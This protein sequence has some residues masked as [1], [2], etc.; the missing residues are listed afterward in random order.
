MTKKLTPEEAWEH[1]K[2]LW[3]D[4]DCISRRNETTYFDCAVYVGN[5]QLPL[6]FINID[7]PEGVTRWPPPESKWRHAE[8]P[9]D[10]GKPCE[11]SDDGT[12]WTPAIICG[13]MP[14]DRSYP[15]LTETRTFKTLA[16]VRDE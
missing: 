10:Y 12:E 15:W 5:T 7:W 6:S 13:Y 8:M 11:V 4:A 16:R 2:A 3:P 1:V 9:R 14:N